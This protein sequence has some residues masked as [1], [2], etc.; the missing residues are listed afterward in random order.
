MK[1]SAAGILV[2]DIVASELPSLPSPGQVMFPPR[3]IKV[4]VGGHPA[5]VSRDLRR[6]NFRGDISVTGSVGADSFG[7]FIQEELERWNI[8]THLKRMEFGDTSKNLILVV[9]GEDRRFHVDV[10]ANLHISSDE[11]VEILYRERPEVLYIGGTGWLGEFDDKLGYVLEKCKEARENCITF[12]DPI[13]PFKKNWS[14]LIPSLKF[15]DLLHCNE[16]ECAY[17]SGEKNVDKALRFFLKRGL[18]II[19][20]T[21]GKRGAIMATPRLKIEIEAF[22]I[23]QVDPTG[24]GDA[25]CA[26]VIHM[27][28]Q[29]RT[30][31]EQEDE[32][33]LLDALKFGSAVGAAATTREGTTEGVDR[34]IVDSLVEKE[35]EYKIQNY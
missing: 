23:K 14:Y 4:G 18:K 12:I 13:A 16:Q 11:V 6:L 28:S 32:D 17:I 3:G 8:T 19:F 25:F 31:L 15:I 5:N 7:N 34:K 27:F 30:A 9:K 20:V 26:G 2:T 24:A 33:I 29:F 10:G 22:K 1:I 35:V 21:R